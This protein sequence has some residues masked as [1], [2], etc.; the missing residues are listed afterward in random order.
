MEL[1]TTDARGPYSRHQGCRLLTGRQAGRVGL[2][3]RDGSALGRSDGRCSTNA[4]GPY[5]RRQGHR[6]LTGRQAGRVG[7]VRQDGPTLGR[8]DGCGPAHL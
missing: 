5:L 7:F 3:R 1:I 6:L 8:S 2:G 4:Q